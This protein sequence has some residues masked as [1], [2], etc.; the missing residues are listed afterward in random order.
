[1]VLQRWGPSFVLSSLEATP[2]SRPEER[3]GKMKEVVEAC[4]VGG[5]WGLFSSIL[6]WKPSR[7]K[8]PFVCVF[9]HSPETLQLHFEICIFN[10]E[11]KY[12]IRGLCCSRHRAQV[13]ERLVP[14]MVVYEYCSYNPAD[15]R[16]GRG[17]FVSQE[18]ALF[19][20]VLKPDDSK[21]R[22]RMFIKLDV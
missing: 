15:C 19:L 7:Y 8:Y 1:M 13:T 5:P 12:L 10:I 11:G 16:S 21:G 6:G 14:H 9:K 3:T 22:C 20:W 4:W 17:G 2:F 18:K